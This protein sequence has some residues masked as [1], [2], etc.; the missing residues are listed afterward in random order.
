MASKE[1]ISRFIPEP[2]SFDITDE[3]IELFWIELFGLEIV[4]WTH[5]SSRRSRVSPERQ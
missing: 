1:R 3:V 2:H 4:S 5:Q